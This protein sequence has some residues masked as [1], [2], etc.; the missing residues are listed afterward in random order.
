MPYPLAAENDVIVE[1]RAAGFTPGELDWPA[2]WADRAGR[3]RTPSVPGHELSGVVAEL[4]YGTTGLTVGQRVF[5]LTDW[6]RDG[7]LA[8]YTAVEAR[9]LAPFAADIKHTVAARAPTSGPAA[10]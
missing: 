6:T 3:D 7:S 2:T 5:G 9:N 8:E 10:R 1:V 4:G